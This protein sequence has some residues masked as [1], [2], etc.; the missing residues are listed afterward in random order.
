MRIFENSGFGTFKAGVVRS[1]PN[2]FWL[3]AGGRAPTKSLFSTMTLH[4]TTSPGCS[5]TPV[6]SSVK[7]DLHQHRLPF[8]CKEDRTMK[9]AKA[10]DGRGVSET[11]TGSPKSLTDPTFGVVQLG[12]LG[13]DNLHQELKWELSLLENGHG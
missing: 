3:A 4:V 9:P 10:R 5:G 11:F 2:M 12:M 1:V 13:S 7:L 8:G 6:R